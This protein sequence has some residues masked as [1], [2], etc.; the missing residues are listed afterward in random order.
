MAKQYYSGWVTKSVLENR[1]YGKSYGFEVDYG[2][3]GSG[4]EGRVFI[5]K[6]QVVFGN[7]NENGNIEMYI[8]KWLFYKNNIKPSQLIGWEW[9][10]FSNEHEKTI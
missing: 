9:G 5:P 8:P 10:D 2:H 1:I 6:S 3:C 7:E 4:H